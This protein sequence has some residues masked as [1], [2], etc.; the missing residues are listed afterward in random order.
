MITDFSVVTF[1]SKSISLQGSAK[2]LNVQK[3]SL[4]TK[5]LFNIDIQHC[6]HAMIY[7]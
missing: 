3:G 7:V 2:I 5:R 6:L 1:L 4:G